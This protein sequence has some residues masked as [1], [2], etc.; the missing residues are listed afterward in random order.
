MSHC[1]ILASAKGGVGKTTVAAGLAVAAAKQGKRVALIDLDPLEQLSRWWELREDTERVRL[2]EGVESVTEALELLTADGWDLVIIDTPPAPLSVALNAM[3][4]SDLVI[5]PCR[6]S[7]LDVDGVAL[8]EE[9]AQ[10]AGKPLAYVLTQVQ[11]GSKL[12]GETRKALAKSGAVLKQSIGLDDAYP[13][14]M[15]RGAMPGEV[16]RGAVRAEFDEVWRE[17][18]GLL[19]HGAKRGGKR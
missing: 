8:T 18:D 11:V 2:V 4:A 17:I 16:G 10:R 15:A 12:L 3:V 6:A 19:E 9:M 7:T 5:V 1:L 13:M 14:A